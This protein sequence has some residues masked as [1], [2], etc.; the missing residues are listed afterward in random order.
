M[1]FTKRELSYPSSDGKNT[2]FAT[3]YAPKN[4]EVRGVVQLSHGMIDY[5]GRYEALADFLTGVGF[6]FAGNEHLGHGRTA[7][8]ASD[9]GFFADKNGYKLV[10]KDLLSMNELLHNEYPDVPLVLFGHSM[11]SFLARLYANEYPETIS[12]LVIHGTG[13][14]NPAA[15][16]GKA[17]V[18]LLS[19]F[20]GNRHRSKL[21]NS[22]A[23]GSYNKK[24]DKA[25]GHN[26]WLTR[27]LSRVATRD[28][29]PYTSFFFTLSGYYDLFTMLERC[30]SKEWFKN[31]KKSLPTLV[32]SG[33]M[34]PVGDYGRGV[35]YVYNGLKAQGV[36]NLSLKTYE[37]ARHELFNEYNMNEVFSDLLLFLEEAVK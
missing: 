25:E 5:V 35:M 11:G 32:M 34:D 36:E 12:A 10:I 22:I 2:V 37:G 16:M 30:N 4:G 13:G 21:I 29:D 15:P 9:F 19:C 26:A 14:K 18:S 24:Y 23:F 7:A 6:V 1:N 20:F 31:Y 28:T 17:L 3:V 27:D 8:S 33:L